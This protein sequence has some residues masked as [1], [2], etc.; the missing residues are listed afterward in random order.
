MERLRFIGMIF[1]F[2]SFRYG[3]S[4]GSVDGGMNK[5]MKHIRGEGCE[6]ANINVG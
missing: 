3:V 2:N 6:T 4:S 5:F 1:G